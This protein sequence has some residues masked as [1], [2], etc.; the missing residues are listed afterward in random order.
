VPPLALTVI[1]P[2]L[3]EAGN[4]AAC[5]ASAAFAGEVIVADGGSIDDT[6]ARAR[7]A[8]A[9]VLENIGPTIA[10]Q[11]NA[12]I[13]AARHPWVLALDADERV[14]PALAAE[15]TRALAAPAHAAY[16]V[17]RRNFYLGVEQTRGGWGR[18]WVVRLFGRERKYVERRVHEGLEPVA[19]I[20]E[21][22]GPLLHHPYR[23]LGHHIEKLNRYAE[24]GAAD[25][26]DR[27]V[28]AT[29]TD[30][31]LRP[32]GRFFK[33]YLLG[34]RVLDGRMGLV[35]S[36]L[37]AYAGFLKYAYLWE[38]GRGSGGAGKRGGE[39]G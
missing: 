9:T 5:V 33:A 2:T 34:G 15:I 3:N 8:G 26:W 18:D 1:I 21:L 30:L 12:A 14:T 17:R 25:L 36:G 31:C 19:D 32:A 16:R 24:W 20:G 37:D 11:R 10:A 29:W 4:I 38:L 7:A 35:Q 23:S 27:G 6:V 13:A 28:R 22:R 39:G